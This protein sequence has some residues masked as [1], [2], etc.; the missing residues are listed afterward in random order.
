MFDLDAWPRHPTNN[1]KFK[2]CLFRA[3][4]IVKNSDKEKYVY[5][6]LYH[7]KFDSVGSWSFGNY[8]ARNLIFGEN[9]IQIFKFWC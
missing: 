3:T 1:F 4:N 8:F 7:Y 5:T 2:N 6:F 9:V